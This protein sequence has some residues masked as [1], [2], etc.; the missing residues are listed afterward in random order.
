MQT[1]GPK[2]HS[3][4]T[5]NDGSAITKRS[6][7]VALFPLCYCSS[8]RCTLNEYP[9]VKRWVIRAIA[10][11]EQMSEERLW[12]GE[13]SAK[14]QRKER[15]RRIRFLRKHEAYN[16]L[17]KSIAHRLALCERYDRCCSGACPACSHLLQRR[18]VGKSK[19]LIRDKIDK[20]DHR[21]V[22]ISIIPSD[23]NIRLGDLHTLSLDNLLRRLK[24][25]LDQAGVTIAIGGIDFSYNE[26]RKGRYRPFWSPHFY[27]ITSITNKRRV[28]RILKTFFKETKSI[29]RPIKIPDFDNSEERRSYAFKN[30]FKRR[31][32]KK[33]KK[34]P[35]GRTCRNTSKDKLR[36][37]ERLEL[38]TFLGQAGF[39][40]RFIFRN[41]KP[42]IKGTEVTLRLARSTSH[43]IKPKR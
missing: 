20:P 37:A 26:D 1:N 16:G 10:E 43:R 8:D 23:L 17:A 18:F 28:G 13:M 34:R 24:Y 9:D 31:I 2:P 14:Y 19:S 3:S 41:V 7:P 29:P 40:S 42:S 39:A 21:L 32:G 25:A 36:A 15:R 22:A 12:K 33:D 38:F 35:D 4:E 11:E 6:T 30:V 5:V 27:L